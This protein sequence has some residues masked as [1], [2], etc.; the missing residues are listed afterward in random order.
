MDEQAQSRALS[1]CS[2]ILPA[3]LRDEDVVSCAD[4]EGQNGTRCRRISDTVTLFSLNNGSQQCCDSKSSAGH[5]P[6]RHPK[7]T[8]LQHDQS[9]S[10]SEETK[11]ILTNS[12]KRAILYFLAIHF[13]PVA[14]TLTLF[15]LYLKN[16]QWKAS[17]IQLK[18]LLFAAKLHETL[19][20]VSLGDILFHRIR[21]HLL[22]SRGVSF[23]LLVSPFRVSDPSFLFQSPFLASAS[24][25]FKSAPELLTILLVLLVS[26]LG[27]LA[28][29]SSG[30]LMTPQYNWWRIPDEGKAMATFTKK[31]LEDA[32]YIGASFEH[33]FPLLI[34]DR[35]VPD[36]TKDD[37]LS[38]SAFSDRFEHILSGLDQ[39]LVDDSSGAAANVTVVDRAT[40]DSFALTYQ[41]QSLDDCELMTCQNISSRLNKTMDMINEKNDDCLNMVC[42]SLTTQVTSPL[43]FVTQEL[44]NRYR[45]WISVSSS[46][47]MI[48][49]KPFSKTKRDLDW[50]QPSVSMQCSTVLHKNP[51]RNA[52][53]LLRPVSFENLGSFPPFT[54]HLDNTF[55]HT[56]KQIEE[57]GKPNTTYIDISH[58]LPPDITISTAL[59]MYDG[60]S[61]SVYHPVYLCLVDARWIE[62]Q[63]WFTAPYATIMRSGISLDSIS[64]GI[65]KNTSA[66]ANSMIAITTQYA[67]SLNSDL[68]V[69]SKYQQGPGKTAQVQPFE[70]IHRYCNQS[71][72]YSLGPKCGMLAHALYLTDSLRRTQSYFRYY[73]AS[74]VTKSDPNTV[75]SPSSKADHLTRLD[76]QLYHQL[77][78][79]KL[80]GL[81]VKLSMS[82]LLLHVM[83]V[84]A[85]LLLLVLG[86]GWYSR[87]WSELGELIALAMVSQ[88]SSLL[89]NAGGGIR[90]WKTW[91]SR[92][93]I[94]EVTPEGRLELV[95]KETIDSP[96]I[97]AD[98][99][100]QKRVHVEPEVNRRYG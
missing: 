73:A 4:S 49:A 74:D 36:Q 98:E 18:S 69:D 81:I 20:L 3:D 38:S 89:H 82:V 45:A 26:G 29:P 84:Y 95:L 60:K 86:D 46:A 47:A 30:V 57:Q 17:D 7:Q 56:V 41:E 16:L 85:H 5:S 91:K 1:Q 40:V 34:D 93:F 27:L 99:E 19:I 28:A 67:N 55:R 77:H 33:L 23:G 97:L 32:K 43:A 2:T 48:K 39:V 14:G 25:T 68:T 87:A 94:R 66:Q 79:Y 54:L 12:K 70:L 88:P 100:G 53:T 13:L 65:G 21:Y 58:L 78:A 71:V 61:S 8:D 51:T 59:F 50:R 64:A 31:E 22:T 92:T 83:L 24:F 80:E 35:F 15:W 6:S 63:V 96:M 44:F 42:E 52:T 72:P 37:R 11:V 75:G 62:S 10:T 76:Y 9:T 90:N